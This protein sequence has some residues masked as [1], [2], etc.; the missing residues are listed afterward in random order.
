MKK[1]EVNAWD[2]YWKLT[3]V[4][5]AF[6]K[7]R[8]NFKC[9]CDCWTILNINLAN[10]RTWH[11]KSCWCIQIKTP[12]NTKHGMHW[13]RIYKTFNNMKDRCNRKKN[14]A[15]NNYGW[16]RIKVEWKSFEDFKNDMYEDYSEHEK[17]HDCWRRYG[18]RHRTGRD[19]RFQRL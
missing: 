14:Q 11:T 16:R 9:K 18:G 10:L 2:K 4:E 7:W 8:R 17:N 6:W 19:P 5:E 12:A 13:H 1:I 15:Y 3:I